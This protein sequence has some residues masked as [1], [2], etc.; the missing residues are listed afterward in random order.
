[1]AHSRWWRPSFQS[2]PPAREETGYALLTETAAFE[3]SIHS[4]RTGGDPDLLV[5][6]PLPNLFQSTPP[7][8][9]ET[10][11]HE[12]LV[13]RHVISIHSSRTGGD[14]ASR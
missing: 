3:I 7:A 1:M 6:R 5:P 14:A 13:R 12:R 4:S 10:Q 9:E 11:L 8:R 2:T